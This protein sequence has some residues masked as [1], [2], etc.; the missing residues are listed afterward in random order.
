MFTFKLR[1][2]YF[3][4]FRIR[5]INIKKNYLKLLNIKATYKLPRIRY[6]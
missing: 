1:I 6:K 2:I 4:V 5:N 3:I